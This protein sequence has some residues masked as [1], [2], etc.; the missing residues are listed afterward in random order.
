[1]WVLCAVMCWVLYS[2]LP[3]TAEWSCNGNILFSEAPIR[4]R[5]RHGCLTQN[6][7][8]SPFR[9]SLTWTKFFV[10]ASIGLNCFSCTQTSGVIHILKTY[11]EEF[12]LNTMHTSI[13]HTAQ[14]NKKVLFLSSK[15]NST[16]YFKHYTF[17]QTT[18]CRNKNNKM[19]FIIPAILVWLFFCPITT[20][21][22]C[23]VLVYV[24]LLFLLSFVTLFYFMKIIKTHWNENCVF[25]FSKPMVFC[26][27]C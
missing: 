15:L 5:Y 23:L 24:L 12:I 4:T 20:C 21:S 14:T 9:K 17:I 13:P 1:M 22:I 3:T 18:N 2:A 6:L 8:L 27:S 19:V 11:P 25:N 7:T 10:F 26:G 16:V